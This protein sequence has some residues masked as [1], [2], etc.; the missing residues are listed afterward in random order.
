MESKIMLHVLT[1]CMHLV[2]A[3]GFK[4]GDTPMH[5]CV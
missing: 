4:G 2:K 3:T 5:A 1:A